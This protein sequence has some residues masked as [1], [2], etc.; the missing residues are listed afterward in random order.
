MEPIRSTIRRPSPPSRPYLRLAKFERLSGRR[1]DTEGLFTFLNEAA[2]LATQITAADGCCEIRLTSTESYHGLA[3]SAVR[4]SSDDDAAMLG[5]VEGRLGA[6]PCQEAFTTARACY[7]SDFRTEQRW[8]VFTLAARSHGFGS[9][10]AQPLI[11]RSGIVIGTLALYSRRSN[12]Y[13][14]ADRGQIVELATVVADIIRR[15]RHLAQP[16]TPPSTATEPS[17]DSYER[18]A[19]AAPEPAV[20][21][22][23][24][25]SEHQGVVVVAVTG[26]VDIAT[27]PRLRQ[28]LLN[29]L[30]SR[31][32]RLIVALERVPFMDATGLGVIAV[33]HRYAYLTGTQLRI[34][35]PR[36]LVRKML[37]LTGM[38]KTLPVFPSFADA[39][40]DALIDSPEIRP[41]S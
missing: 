23:T 3:A 17:P 18:A 16:P 37:S 11:D 6:G 21:F 4:A 8:P 19:D 12:A 7:L 36:R 26:D 32:A 41:A 34:A 38:D 25:S 27:S 2:H 39:L 33:V 22:E 30:W 15:P 14:V 31:P 5:T 29:L 13:S 24:T 40:T 28:E 35:G 10:V 20:E 9:M 1:A